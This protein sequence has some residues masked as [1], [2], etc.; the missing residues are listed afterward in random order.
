MAGKNNKVRPALAIA[1]IAIVVFL[2]WAVASSKRGRPQSTEHLQQQ[3]PAHSK[4]SRKNLGRRQYGQE[5]STETKPQG[6]YPKET[7]HQDY[8]ASSG[9]GKTDQS[10]RQ[11]RPQLTDVIRS[12]TRW[13]AILD[14]FYNQKAPNFTLTDID[15]KRHSLSDYRG[16]SVMVVWWAT[17]C[18]PCVMEV[19]HLIALRNTISE[20]ELAILAITRENPRIVR[21]FVDSRKIN[22]TVLLDSG[23]LP[24]PFNIVRSIPSSFFVT[25]DGRIKVITEGSL[26]LGDMKALL[27]AE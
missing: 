11:R 15:G 16:K 1:A 23:K 13:G 12:A 8:Y 7:L 18:K 24:I 2:I 20:D 19:P 25:R 6:T 4:V 17:W 5:S 9:S 3:N 10:Q 27:R 26:S 22:Y 14:Q 21:A